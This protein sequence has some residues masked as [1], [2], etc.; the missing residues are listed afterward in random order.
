[1]LSIYKALKSLL[2]INM[3]KSIQITDF[4]DAITSV[5]GKGGRI[6]GFSKYVGKKC[7]VIIEEDERKVKGRNGD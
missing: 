3:A 7:L 1:M 6:S 2:R 5:V 4:N